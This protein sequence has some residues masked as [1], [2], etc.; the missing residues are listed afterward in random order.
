MFVLK[1]ECE[2]LQSPGDINMAF[3]DGNCWVGVG[4][5]SQSIGSPGVVGI[6]MGEEDGGG[7]VCGL[8]WLGARRPEEKK[9]E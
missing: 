8:P 5:K 3:D 9:L 7:G 6:I 4:V 1:N 2:L